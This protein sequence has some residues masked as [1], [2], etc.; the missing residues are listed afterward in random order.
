[1]NDLEILRQFKAINIFFFEEQQVSVFH[2][3]PNLLG[4]PN[5]QSVTP[6]QQSLPKY[7]RGYKKKTN[8]KTSTVPKRPASNF[9]VKLMKH[10]FSS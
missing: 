2:L 5:F 9:P 1:M 8:Q 10:H 3:S 4:F 6:V 7:K